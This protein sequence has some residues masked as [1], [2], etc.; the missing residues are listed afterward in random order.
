MRFV[1]LFYILTT[2]QEYHTYSEVWPLKIYRL[3]VPSPTISG[4]SVELK[5]NYEM[6]AN[7]LYSV[8]WYKDTSEFY[9]YVPK[10]NPKIKV[11]SL[12]GI[13]VDTT[14]S[15]NE[16]VYLKYVDSNSAG[17]YRCEISA[18]APSFVT[19]AEEKDMEIYVL[20]QEIPEIK[21]TSDRQHHTRGDVLSATCSSAKSKPR[22]KLSWFI[23][24]QPITNFSRSDE[25][26][27]E[28]STDLHADSGLESTT[29]NLTFMITDKHYS[30]GFSSFRLKC[31]AIIA[32]L[33]KV[34]DNEI[35]VPLKM[36]SSKHL[37]QLQK[38]S[39]SDNLSQ[40]DS[41]I[42]WRELFHR[43][44]LK[45][46]ATIIIMFLSRVWHQQQAL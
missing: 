8:K 7:K 4:Q 24:Y 18:E 19:T 41:S 16:S 11:L 21:L 25:Y 12:K 2:L 30:P 34:L 36:D 42:S 37:E 15:S 46:G 5:C 27:V 13:K 14:R 22:A 29:S 31:K 38:G 3:E 35:S 44:T 9:R 1:I 43:A 33:D 40:P 17:K 6:G 20:P 45:I 28:Y 10:D 32:E 39:V 26:K 23:D